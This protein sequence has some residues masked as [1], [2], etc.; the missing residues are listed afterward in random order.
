MTWNMQTY[1]RRGV[2][3]IYC[4]PVLKGTLCASVWRARVSGSASTKPHTVMNIIWGLFTTFTKSQ[5]SSI[6][7]IRSRD[8]MADKCLLHPHIFLKTDS[9][10][11]STNLDRDSVYETNQVLLMCKNMDKMYITDINI[12]Y[13]YPIE[14]RSRRCQHKPNNFLKQFTIIG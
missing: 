11:C 4:L 1:W 6:T 9:Q 10:G 5:T 13:V 7:V 3:V 14:A 8:A 2:V 12:S